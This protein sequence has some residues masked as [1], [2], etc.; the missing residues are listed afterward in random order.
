EVVDL[1]MVL[2]RLLHVPQSKAKRECP[3]GEDRVH[4]VALVEQR[5]CQGVVG[6]VRQRRGFR[7]SLLNQLLD[8]S[9]VQGPG[10]HRV[11]EPEEAALSAAVCDWRRK[12]E[13]TV[14]PAYR[15]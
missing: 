5:R 14:L 11:R 12:T 10:R 13:V 15:P 6:V 3:S 1:L 8:I 7:C 9:L 4:S 2:N